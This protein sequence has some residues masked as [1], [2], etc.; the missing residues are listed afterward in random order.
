MKLGTHKEYDKPTFMKHMIESSM[1]RKM[2]SNIDSLF[3]LL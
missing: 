3:D 1:D 2:N